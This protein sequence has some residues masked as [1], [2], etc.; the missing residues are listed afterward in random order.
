MS[1]T[2]QDMEINERVAKVFRQ[3][4]G[5][6]VA[7]NPNLQRTDVPAWTSMKHVEFIIALEKAFTV[8]FDGA[9]ATD[10]VSAQVVLERLRKKLA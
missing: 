9:D 6:N 8:R 3:T 10:M 1:A 2:M 7:F 5:R 4:F